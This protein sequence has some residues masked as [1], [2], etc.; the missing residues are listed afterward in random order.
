MIQTDFT[1]TFIRG[2]ISAEKK[3]PYLQVS[4]GR[5]E[6]FVNFDKDFKKQVGPSTFDEYSEGDEI[7]LTVE[8]LPGS[9]TV[10]VVGFAE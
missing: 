5:K 1:F 2:G 3:N 4:N 6:L 10:K 8:I 9:D 7:S